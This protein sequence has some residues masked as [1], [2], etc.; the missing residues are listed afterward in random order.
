[1]IWLGLFLF[2]LALAVLFVRKRLRSPHALARSGA[3]ERL[4]ALLASERSLA[5]ARDAEGETPVHAAAKY[6]EVEALRVALDAGGKIDARAEGGPTPLLLATAMGCPG[7]VRLLIERGADLD[8]PDDTGVTPLHFAIR[9]GHEEIARALL[10]AGA[11]VNMKQAGQTTFDAAIEA[12]QTDL[13]EAIAKKGGLPGAEVRMRD[14]PPPRS[15]G[16]HRTPSIVATAHDD[17]RMAGAVAE[18]KRTLPEL[19]ALH[20]RHPARCALKFELIG[21]ES[22]QVWGFVQSVSSSG[23]EVRLLSDPLAFTIQPGGVHTV[24]WDRVTDWLVEVE[25][26]RRRGGYTPRVMCA[27]VREEYG[28]LDGAY[29][30]LERSLAAGGASEGES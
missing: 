18:A 25:P 19:R 13:A 14:V 5:N 10:D 8:E 30:E 26:G 24:T 20:A 23:A 3:A 2:V 21:S 6:D 4:R 27:E 11:Q 9:A 12:G 15:S 28:S 16:R 29:L 7:A 17:A 22:E 1:M